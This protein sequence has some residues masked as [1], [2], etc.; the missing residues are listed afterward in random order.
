VRIGLRLCDVVASPAEIDRFLQA[1]LVRRGRGDVTAVEAASWLDE[2]G[3]LADSASRPGLPL[4][5][6]LRAGRIRSGEQRP[7]QKHGSW[8]IVRR[9]VAA[10][11]GDSPPGTHLATSTP[12][13]VA[14]AVEN[15]GHRVS[16]EWMGQ[17]IV[18]LEDLLRPEL[19]VLCIGINPAVTSVERGHYYQGASG[20]RFLSRLR[21]VGL[22]PEYDGRWEDDVA[23]ELGTGQTDV[24][25][26][27]TTKADVIGAAEF[28]YG[29]REL[30]RRLADVRAELAIFTF[31]A[32]A[33]K[34]FGDFPGHG[35]IT[36]AS[37][38]GGE[39]FVMPGPYQKADVAE[40]SLA[41]LRQSLERRSG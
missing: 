6:L 20:Q 40:A 17:K 21:E 32:A 24:V 9:D 34:I 26:R 16:M 10:S 3:L 8:F 38:C 35:F 13:R 11:A 37:L 7:P 29:R 27:P 28:A 23:F 19:R 39:V 15:E 4:R 30:A 1:E 25:K 41:T 12:T 2:A 18:T 5:N 31:K 36:G 33:K 14:P 22:L